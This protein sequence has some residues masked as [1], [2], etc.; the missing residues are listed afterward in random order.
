VFG[1]WALPA[2]YALPPVPPLGAEPNPASSNGEPGDDDV[3]PGVCPPFINTVW[4]DWLGWPVF[5]FP[6]ANADVGAATTSDPTSIPPAM[7]IRL[8]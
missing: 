7:S 1:E 6:M 5:G 8:I 4:H 3:L 2:V